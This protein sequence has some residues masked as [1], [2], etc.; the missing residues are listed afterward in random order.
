MK[1]TSL[2][3]LTVAILAAAP[4]A[5]RAEISA[6]S[7]TAQE[8][9]PALAKTAT[10]PVIDGI[11]DDAA[12]ATALKYD[13]FKTFKPD[14]GKDASQKTVAYIAYDA[15]NF[16]FAFRCYDSEPSKVKAA[17]SKRDN[18][19][20]DDI[21]FINLDTFNDNQ[22]AFV[23]MLN[24]LGIQGDGM[25]TVNGNIE[26]SFDAVWYSKGRIDDQG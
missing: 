2:F 10:P 21:V 3:L 19:F 23:F 16:Y 18:V 14:Y 17:V 20:Q 1:K 4:A 9:V 12:W 7:P 5:L 15:E 26:V 25:L 22:S 13:G 24:P 11:L 8:T 6:P